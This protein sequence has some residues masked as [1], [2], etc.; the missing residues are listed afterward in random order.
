MPVILLI[1][2]RL[3]STTTSVAATSN[4]EPPAAATS[5][6]QAG[7]AVHRRPASP[8]A[9]QAVGEGVGVAAMGRRLHQLRQMRKEVSHPLLDSAG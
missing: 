9:R 6:P 2:T 5:G 3:P 7:Y 8:P 4:M 1:L